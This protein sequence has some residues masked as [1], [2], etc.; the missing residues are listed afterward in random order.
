MRRLGLV[1]LLTACIFAFGVISAQ[2]GIIYGIKHPPIGAPAEIY[3]IDLST[4][5]C[6]ITLMATASGGGVPVASSSYNGNGYDVINDRYYFSCFDNSP[7]TLWRIDNFSTAPSVPVAVGTLTG[8]IS[9]GSFYEE[10]YYCV[11]HNTDDLYVVEFTATGLI[12]TKIAD[13]TGNTKN[14]Y[15][16]DIAMGPGG[17]LYG[18]VGT[19]IPPASAGGSS[20]PEFFIYDGTTYTAYPKAQTGQPE[21]LQIAFGDNGVLYGYSV[22]TN[23]FYSIDTSNGNATAI[24]TSTKDF[25]DLAR[26]S[27]EP[28]L[29]PEIN[30]KPYSWPN[31]INTCSSG[32]TPVIIWGSESFDVTK[33]LLDTLTFGDKGLKVVG[34]GKKELFVID[35]FGQPDPEAFDQ[36][37]PIP[38][39]Y[40]DLNAK[41]DTYELSTF[42]EG[43]QTL[44]KVCFDYDY[45]GDGSYVKNICVTQEIFLSRDCSTAE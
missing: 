43:S 15:F 31:A 45:Y 26:G 30:I 33:I 16:G 35:D 32:G 12:E 29:V 41:F 27:E 40:L 7:R 18:S 10:K 9:N 4:D 6:I 37:N 36:I 39:G 38:D 23:T 1:V 20:N 34:K 21:A 22:S 14:L 19:A 11:G 28:P 17:V 5:S 24:C 3:K 8:G 2:A 13:I 42:T 25:G 44:G